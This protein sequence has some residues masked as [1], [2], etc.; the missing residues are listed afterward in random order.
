MLKAMDRCIANLA[1]E[2]IAENVMEGREQIS[3]TTDKKRMAEWVKS[4]IGKLDASVD[5]KTKFQIMESCGRNCA[6]VNKSVIERAKARRRKHKSVEEFLKA[7]QEKPAKGT[8]LVREDDI[9]YQVYTPHAFTR[10][11]RCYCS[12][13]RGLPVGEKISRTYCHCAKG[14]VRKLWEN[15]LERP[16]KVELVQSAVSGADECKFAIHL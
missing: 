2:R 3:R 4:A 10:P 13:L 6:E 5:E 9:L 12:L 14:F 11:M 16:V 7:E 8:R 1:G 15:V